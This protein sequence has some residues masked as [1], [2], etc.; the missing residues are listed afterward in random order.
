MSRF[1]DICG[2]RNTTFI[3]ELF[4]SVG[5]CCLARLSVVQLPQVLLL[6][7]RMSHSLFLWRGQP[8][9]NAAHITLMCRAPPWQRV[10]HWHLTH[11]LCSVWLIRAELHLVC[12]LLAFILNGKSERGCL[13]VQTSV[14]SVM[15]H[16]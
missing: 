11:V 6:P 5:H 8:V 10:P 16:A 12:H 3:S 15:Q 4:L 2:S 13:S 14:F 1:Q 7:T 9:L